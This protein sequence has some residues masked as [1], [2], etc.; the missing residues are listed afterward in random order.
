MLD[1]T[2]MNESLVGQEIDASRLAA[3]GEILRTTLRHDLRTP[4]GTI[5]NYATILETPQGPRPE[6][7]AQFAQHIRQNA[8]RTASMLDC[9]SS[10]AALALKVTATSDVDLEALLKSTMS[11]LG[12][13]EGRVETS[14]EPLAKGVSPQLLAFVWRSFLCF[15]RDVR[16]R[17][18]KEV[19]LTHTSGDDGDTIELCVG[20]CSDDSTPTVELANYLRDAG[21]HAHP[22][23]VLA[24]RLSRELALLERGSFELTGRAGARSTVK[25]RLAQRR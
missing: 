2:H 25:L 13:R 8:M 23:N 4:L 10:A 14:G 9:L 24:M 17:L 7:I 5:V 20:P 1:G 19:E 6:E 12:G 22:E 3:F 16:G 18:P 11:E 15:D 21:D